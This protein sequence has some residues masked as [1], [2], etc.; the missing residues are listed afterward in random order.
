MRLRRIGS[1]LFGS[2]V[3]IAG[4]ACGLD[5]IGEGPA[6]DDGGADAVGSASGSGGGADGAGSGSGSGGVSGGSSGSASGSSSGSG[7]GG[8]SGSS[9]GSGSGSGSGGSGSGSGGEGGSTGPCESGWTLVLG[10]SGGGMCPGGYPESYVGV[11]N[12]QAQPGACTCSCTIA[13]P[14]SCTTGNVNWSFGTQQPW[15]LGSS[16]VSSNG[17]CQPMNGNLQQAQSVQPLPATGGACT[18]Q[19]AGDTTK[20]QTTQVR[21]CSV[22]S[23]DEASV[24]AG[25]APPGSSA[26]LV[27]PGDVPCPQASPFQI[28]AVIADSETLVCSACSSCSVTAPC[29][30][31]ELDVYSDQGCTTLVVAIPANGM[32]SNVSKTGNVQGYWYKAQ[33]GTPMC[34]ATGGAAS[35]QATNAQTL[36][37]R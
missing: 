9:S 33:V 8:A 22:P 34:N 19:V 16:P 23:S 26:C 1:I 27:A 13:Q 7:S 17:T 10:V 12:P 15:C 3:A 30:S 28:R 4:T 21:T 20:V 36:C 29:M 37:C 2:V 14:P 5:P 6:V 35:F 24:C 18:G 32:C 25:V 11:T 31:P